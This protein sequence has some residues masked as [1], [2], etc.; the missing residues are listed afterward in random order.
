MGG[1]LLFS[2]FVIDSRYKANIGSN[3][4]MKKDYFES[5]DSLA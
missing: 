5:E 2:G 4:K 3:D 1:V